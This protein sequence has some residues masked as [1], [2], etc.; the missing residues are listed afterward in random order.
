MANLS[1]TMPCCYFP[2]TVLLIDDEKSF[3]KSFHIQ[4]NRLTKP[5]CYTDPQL[6]LRY[7]TQEYKPIANPSQ[8]ISSL[9]YDEI[10]TDELLAHEH[11]YLDID[12]FAIHKTLYR[13]DRF[14]EISV[15]ISDYAMSGINGVEVF[16]QLK[17]YHFKKCLLTGIATETTAVEAF[18]QG[19][20]DKFILKN[21]DSLVSKTE[22][23]AILADLQKQYFEALSYDVMLRLVNNPKSCV[24]EPLFKTLF[25]RI[26]QENKIIEYYLVSESGCF[27]MFDIDN[28]PYWLIVKSEDDMKYYEISASE[29]DA[30]ASIT[31][32]LKKRKKVLFLFTKKDDE[33]VPYT[34]WNHY[35]HDA[36]KL[37]G[38]KNTFYYSFLKGKSVYDLDMKK[39]VSYK[40]YSG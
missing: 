25:D 33:E 5:L 21:P 30:P 9:K 4:I 22:L 31:N 2:T 12:F 20:I 16:K 24:G 35:L 38:E 32:A 14:K 15:V 7:L 28:N 17:Q 23:N 27:L 1:N 29:N 13:P 3:L 34:E 6:A 18:N 40:K 39:I 10:E 36:E 26:V 11:G 37:K 19:I 8:W